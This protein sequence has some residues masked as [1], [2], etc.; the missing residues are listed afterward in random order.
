MSDYTYYSCTSGATGYHGE[1]KITYYQ[2]AYDCIA[3]TAACSSYPYTIN[4]NSPNNRFKITPSYVSCVR[5]GKMVKTEPINIEEYQ[6]NRF[7]STSG[8]YEHCEACKRYF[9]RKRW[10][11]IRDDVKQYGAWDDK[12]RTIRLH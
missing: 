2:Q 8:S 3:T 5:C 10:I 4:S 9:R 1:T 11:R 6:D 12:R 7:T